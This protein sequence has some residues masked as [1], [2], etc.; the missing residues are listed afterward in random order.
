MI[1]VDASALVDLLAGT[2]RSA[3]VARSLGDSDVL[4]APELLLVEVTSALWRLCRT[5]SLRAEVATQAV[6][7]LIGMPVTL[8]P[9]RDLVAA[10]WARR[11]SVRLADAYYLACAQMLRAP[12][13][14]TDAR[15]ARGPHVGVTVTLA[16]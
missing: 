6:R 2:R 14:T 16:G 15:L 4:F 13:V 8:V 1:V 10:A 11:E 3:T 9:H 7:Q 12:L 5:G